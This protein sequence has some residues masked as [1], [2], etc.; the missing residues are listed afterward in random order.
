V[1]TAAAPDTSALAALTTAERR[2]LVALCAPVLEG[3]LGALPATNRRIAEELSLTVDG[4]K[5]RIK[6]LFAKLEID[7]LPHHHKRSELARRAIAAGMVGSRDLAP[8]S[9]GVRRPGD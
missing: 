3:G 7:D 8:R 2:T 9:D 6:A 4:V 5:A 1:E